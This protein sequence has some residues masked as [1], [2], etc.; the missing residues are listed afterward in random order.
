[1]SGFG[2]QEGEPYG[3]DNS[4]VTWFI[5]EGIYSAISLDDRGQF[6]ALTPLAQTQ[7]WMNLEDWTLLESPA[8]N[9]KISDVAPG[10]AEH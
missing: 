7:R 2:C 8:A 3:S 4:Y 1:M 5:P 9:R 6:A 10:R